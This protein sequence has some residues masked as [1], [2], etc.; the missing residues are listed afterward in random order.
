LLC[1]GWAIG[2]FAAQDR[3]VDARHFI[4]ERDSNKLEGLGVASEI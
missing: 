1:R 2:Y 3:E 4:G